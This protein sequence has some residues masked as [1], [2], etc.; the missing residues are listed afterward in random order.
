M[1]C[2]GSLWRGW[3]PLVAVLLLVV[4]SVQAL[5]E[6]ET[7]FEPRHEGVDFPVGW[8][9]FNLAG[10]F[11]PQVRMVYPAMLDGEDEE[12]AGNGPFAWTVF[13]GDTGE[14]IDGYMEWASAVTTRGFI[15]MVTQ[16]VND[17]TDVETTVDLLTTLAQSMEQQN[18]T[19]LRVMGSAGNIDLSHWGVSGHGRGAAAAYGAFPFWG[20]SSRAADL[21]PPRALFGLGVDLADFP[22]D[23]AW[24]DLSSE[25]AFP[26][27]N[28]AL[29]ITGTVDEIAPSQATMERVQSAG[30]IGWQWMHLLGAD[31]YQFQDTRSIF[32][33][34][35]EA[36]MSQSEQINASAQHVV[37]YLDTVLHGDHA[38][39]RTAFNRP[40]APRTVSDAQAYVDEDL[41]RSSFLRWS[42]TSASH[43][44]NDTLD[45]NDAFVMVTNWSL[46]D[47]RNWA[48]LPAGW[49]VNVTCGWEDGPWVGEGAVSV[50]GTTSCTF[51]MA[52]V[53]PGVHQAWMRVEVEGAPSTWFAPALRNN[54]PIDL[55][56]PQPTVY[57]PQHGSVVSNLSSVAI[58]PDG[59]AVRL[60]SASLTGP[61]ASHFEVAVSS[62]GLSFTVGHALDEEWLG[63]CMVL[64]ELQSDGGVIDRVNTSLRVMLTPVDDQVVKN[65]TVPIQEMSEDSPAT[66]VDLG[67]FVSDPEGEELLIRIGGEAVGEQGP[68]RYSIDGDRLTLLPLPN[69]FGATVLQALVSDGVNP[70]VSLEIPVVINAV[71][72][73][74]SVNASMWGAL[75][76][77]ED[78]ELQLDLSTFAFDVDGDE[79]VWTLEG[80]P[81]T[82]SFVRNTAGYLLSP[83]VD[84]NG[85]VGTFWLNVSDGTSAYDDEM[86]LTVLP[87]PDA[88]FVNII[89]VQRLDQG[90][91]ASMQWAVRDVDGV[92]NTSA[93]VQVDGVVLSVN[94]SC[95]GEAAGVH[96]CVTLLPLPVTNGSVY[97]EVKVRDVALDRVV[98][99]AYV[100]DP[101]SS[102]NQSS[103]VVDDT[104]DSAALVYPVLGVVLAVALVLGALAARRSFRAPPSARPPADEVKAMPAVTERKGL[105]ERSKER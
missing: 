28:T 11:S 63:E 32:E 13:I 81:T 71:N 91:T 101:L 45:A 37:A 76:V 34:E 75:I 6:E 50:N 78:E 49:D 5:L 44:A 82:V 59:Q 55:L 27:P 52:E 56:Y 20:M 41:S 105:L 65:G 103:P 15:V 102:N 42:G 53:A 89:S 95:L 93:L 36:T 14:N 97:I 74:V 19:N 92:A 18:Q 80:L 10:T 58:D 99:A 83:T 68:V 29:F 77:L 96:Q 86:S 33:G 69:Q 61:D 60:V 104:K 12:M 7:T 100:F 35:D 84:F 43:Q 31:H 70:S 90:Q 21:H 1:T 25:S 40:E 8:T 26:S 47:G 38:R 2:R 67:R 85:E 4:P 73:P 17:E 88:P 57:V 48:S 9:D 22:S 66:M 3:C 79:L 54:T 51:D 87:V 62:D 39:Y 23:F 16:P 30:G 64:L 46:R 72:D 98:V 94:H 24:D